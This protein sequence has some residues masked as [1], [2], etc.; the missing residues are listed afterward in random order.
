MGK[1]YICIFLLE[2]NCEFYILF[3]CKEEDVDYYDY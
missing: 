2:K 1:G 3:V